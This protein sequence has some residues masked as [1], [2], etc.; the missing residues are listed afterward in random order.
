SRTYSKSRRDALRSL[1]RAPSQRSGPFVAEWRT[2]SAWQTANFKSPLKQ[3]R[4]RG[5]D[6][7][8]WAISFAKEFNVY[9]GTHNPAGER[10][11]HGN[12]GIAPVRAALVRNGEKRVSEPRGKVARGVDRVAGRGAEREADRPNEQANQ[13]RR[14]AA[15]GRAR[16]P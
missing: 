9:S 4:E 12:P 14:Q 3:K 11:D 15:R 6:A 10:P 1:H 5:A 8:I 2:D 16:I 7:T 13:E